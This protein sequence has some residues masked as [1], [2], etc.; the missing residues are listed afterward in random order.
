[1][2][3]VCSIA[4][5]LALALSIGGCP[6]K[7][8]DTGKAGPEGSKE[9][10]AGEKAAPKNPNALPADKAWA[11]GK[12][13]GAALGLQMKL[14]LPKTKTDERSTMTYQLWVTD[15]R[16]RWVFTTPRSYVPEGTELRYN[17]AENKYV[18][19][20]PGKKSYWVMKGAALAN[21]LE[22]GPALSRSNYA[23]KVTD[24]GKKQKIAGY[25]ATRSDAEI[26]FDWT[27]KTK[28]GE[29]KGKIKVNASIWHVENDELAAGWGDTMIGFLLMPFQD[30]QGQ[31]V[32]DAL[33]K[34]IAFPV[35]WSLKIIQ[36]DAKKK[37]GE[38][39]PEL[40]TTATKVEVKEL[41]KTAFAWP[42]AGF[43]PA[44]GPYQFGEDGQ[45]L[46]EA[47]MKK[48]PAKKGKK[49]E[50]VEPAGEDKGK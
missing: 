22:G 2:R 10:K 43:S 3:R 7:K 1:M 21:L 29:K 20:D 26:T 23:I 17:G 19:V 49:P 11:S 38:A 15:D 6:K 4:A 50:G 42:P 32:I 37:K 48:L 9:G 44:S 8:S 14:V 46:S 45:T 30:E 27:V 28:G 47:E 12:V 40:V 18:L 36:Q 16:G 35:K 39:F 13:R 25:E 24:T 31:K 33:K 5:L 34:E 41:D